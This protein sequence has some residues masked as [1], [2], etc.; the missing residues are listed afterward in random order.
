MVVMLQKVSHTAAAWK[1]ELYSQ[2]EKAKLY[3]KIS[4]CNAGYSA[5]Y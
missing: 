3:R 5:E 1:G 4:A 2:R